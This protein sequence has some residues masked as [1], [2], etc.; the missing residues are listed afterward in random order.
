MTRASSGRHGPLL[1]GHFLADLHHVTLAA[2]APILA[3][4]TCGDRLP[5]V[6]GARPWRGRLGGPAQPRTFAG[7]AWAVTKARVQA[8]H[9]GAPLMVRR[10][11]RAPSQRHRL[12]ES[13]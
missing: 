13:D 6:S 3:R 2:R 12:N 8:T 4:K 11:R 10:Q 9:P 5:P 1:A 7:I